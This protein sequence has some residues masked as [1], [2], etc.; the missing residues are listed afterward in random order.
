VILLYDLDAVS[1]GHNVDYGATVRVGG[2]VD[3]AK[4]SLHNNHRQLS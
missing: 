3:V 1:D 4:L 2:Y